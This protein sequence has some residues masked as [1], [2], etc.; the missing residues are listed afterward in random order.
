MAIPGTPVMD[1][2]TGDQVRA[3][4]AKGFAGTLFLSTDDCRAA[5]GGLRGREPFALDPCS[6]GEPADGCVRILLTG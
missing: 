1:A 2:A 3:L 6:P 5:F 4:M